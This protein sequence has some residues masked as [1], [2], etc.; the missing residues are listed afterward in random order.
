MS[1]CAVSDPNL[2]SLACP[3]SYPA[4]VLCDRSGRVRALWGSYSEQLNK[5]ETEWTAG[6]L[7]GQLLGGG[8]V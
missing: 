3:L 7:A 4:G 8:G 5:E 6:A 2:R 1:P